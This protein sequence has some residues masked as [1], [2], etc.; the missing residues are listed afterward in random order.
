MLCLVFVSVIL[1]SCKAETKEYGVNE[2]RTT[3]E[4]YDGFKIMQL[5]DLHFGIESDLAL[6]M[7]VIEKSVIEADPDLIILT[8]DNFMYG[9]KAIA[10]QLFALMNSLCKRLSEE[11]ANGRITKFAVTFGNHDN[12]GD[13]PRYYLNEVISSYA[14]K[15]GEELETGKFAAFVDHEDDKLFGLTNYFIDLVDDRSKGTDTVDVKYRIHLIDSNTYH[16]MGLDYDYDVIHAEQLEHA[17][18]IYEKATAD[19]NYVGMCFFHIPFEEYELAATQYKSASDPSLVGQG[20]N[21]EEV[22][23]PYENNGSFRALRDANIV[24]FVVGHDHINCS[25]IVY[26]KDGEFKD[27]AILSYGVKA[28]DQVYHDKDMLGYKT[29][30]LEDISAEEFVTIENVTKN[31]KNVRT[32]AQKYD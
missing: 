15:D 12:Q 25:D 7:N 29:I 5:A 6:Q 9:N 3:M 13:Y 21:R 20:E 17:K 4:Y 27:R 14:A 24:S 31:F 2:Y 16:F 1:F 8:G 32:G 23:D 11:D 26:N 10:D 18:K 28:T 19:R 30:T 22:L